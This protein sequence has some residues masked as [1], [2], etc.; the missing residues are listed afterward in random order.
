MKIY[1]IE[2]VHPHC[3]KK[4]NN[5]KHEEDHLEVVPRIKMLTQDSSTE[6]IK[7]GTLVKYCDCAEVTQS[8]KEKFKQNIIC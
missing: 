3:S 1:L 8:G 5:V 2:Y 7:S 6:V 4:Y